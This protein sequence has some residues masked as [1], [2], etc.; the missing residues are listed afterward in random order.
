MVKCLK[1]NEEKVYYGKSLRCKSCN[2]EY[3]SKWFNSNRN[4]QR[5]RVRDNTVKYIVRNQQYVI[6]YLNTH[7]CVDCGQT[8][9]LVL[10]FDHTNNDKYK[11]IADMIRDAHS[12]QTLIKEINKCEVV[13]A[14]CHRIRTAY[15]FGSYRLSYLL[16]NLT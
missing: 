5:K 15:Q 1:H 10:D 4:T 7:P 8:N 12:L 16:A 3:Q 2:R 9:I 11:N 6:N 13:C 14:N